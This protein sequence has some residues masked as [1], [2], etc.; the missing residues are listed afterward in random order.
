M[1]SFVALEIRILTVVCCIASMKAIAV[2]VLPVPGG[3]CVHET[4]WISQSRSALSCV[5]PNPCF[6][7]IDVITWHFHICSKLDNGKLSIHPFAFIF[8]LLWKTRNFRTHCTLRGGGW[9]ASG[10]AQ[11][12]CGDNRTKVLLQRRG[13][14][15][16]AKPGVLCPSLHLTRV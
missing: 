4:R 15:T 2:R 5:L 11:A 8:L 1:P 14:V 10:C 6:L 3:P 7:T 13:R 16:R 12:S 9:Q